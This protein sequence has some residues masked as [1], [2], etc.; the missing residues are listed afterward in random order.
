MTDNLS[1]QVYV[2]KISNGITFK[3]K[4]GYYLELLTT[5]NMKLIGSTERQITKDKNGE[6]VSQ[7]EITEIVLVH[8]NILNKQYQD[9][10]FLFTVVP[11]KSS[12]QISN[13]LQ[14]NHIYPHTFW[15]EFP[16]I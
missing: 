13:I 2:N 15:S 6:N 3:I 11:N 16:Y 14:T 1:I 4:T 7:Q 10:R 5:E 12:D 8:C 9:L